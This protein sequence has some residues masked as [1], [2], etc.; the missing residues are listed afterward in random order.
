[1]SVKVCCDFCGKPLN[2]H[3]EETD[4]GESVVVENHPTK[5]LNT[6]EMFTHLCE[7]CS[8]KLDD[9]LVYARREWEKQLDISSRNAVINKE[10]R[11]KLGTKG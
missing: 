6:R 2:E 9:V 11:E 7:D 1:M 5:E 8:V 10:R 3:I 4:F